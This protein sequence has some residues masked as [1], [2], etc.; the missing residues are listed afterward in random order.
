MI[1]KCGHDD[2]LGYL[3][4]TPCARCVREAHRR[5]VGKPS[6]GSIGKGS[7]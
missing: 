2:P 6:K 3:S 7:K 4:G 5:A 1:A